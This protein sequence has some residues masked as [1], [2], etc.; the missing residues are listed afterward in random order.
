MN[1]VTIDKSEPSTK[2][3]ACIP[4]NFSDLAILAVFV[5]CE[6]TNWSPT[7]CGTE[8]CQSNTESRNTFTEASTRYCKMDTE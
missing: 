4:I 5:Q 3:F 2:L 1:T 6:V 8:R 7:I